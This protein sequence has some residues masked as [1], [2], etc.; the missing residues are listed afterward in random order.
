MTPKEFLL[1]AGHCAPIVSALVCVLL[2]ALHKTGRDAPY[3]TLNAYFLTVAFLWFCN[4]TYIYLPV[5]YTVIN[6]L[7]YLGLFLGQIFFYRFIY[8]LTR[9][10]GEKPFSWIHSLVPALIIGVFTAWSFFVP[11][12]VQLGIVTSRGEFAPGYE[13]YSRLF[14]ARLVL[15]GIWNIFYT[16]LAWWRLLRYRRTVPDF[17]ADVDRSSLRWVTLLLILSFSLVPPSL[18]AATFP[19]QELI[20]SLLLLI[21][22]LL[23][24]IQHAVVCYNMAVG[25]FVQIKDAAKEPV[26]KRFPELETH[27]EMERKRRRFERY[28]RDAKPF[29]NPELRITDLAVSF[30]T[31]RTYLSAFINR[32]YGLNF[33]CYINQLRIQ[34]FESLRLDPEYSEASKDEVASMA[35]FEN[36]KRYLMVKKE[37]SIIQ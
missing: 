28:M 4:I 36:Y 32:T 2:L 6:I 16:V 11:F 5:L 15:R 37:M 18:L 10:P 24:V 12:D 34:E 35:G 1:Y 29:R 22:Q 23:L 31:N 27:A 9:L 3:R 19:R 17:S 14:T 25:N 20:T 21:P 13:A 30:N 8:S 26:L 7:Y 33:S